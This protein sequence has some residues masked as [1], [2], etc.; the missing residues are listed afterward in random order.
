MYRRHT[1]KGAGKGARA[2][3][4][5]LLKCPVS[6]LYMLPIWSGK[7]GVSLTKLCFV[8]AEPPK[9]QEFTVRSPGENAI[10]W[11]KCFNALKPQ[12]P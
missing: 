1:S 10:K 5:P 7:S 8:A 2:T 12:Q 11:E 4:V 9:V 6:R 3:Y